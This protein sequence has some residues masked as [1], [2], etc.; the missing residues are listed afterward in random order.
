M[1]RKKQ[2]QEKRKGRKR[3]NKG[4]D[5]KGKKEKDVE[6]EQKNRE[7]RYTYKKR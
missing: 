2:G 7:V 4:Q 6:T 3:G 1:Q 5:M